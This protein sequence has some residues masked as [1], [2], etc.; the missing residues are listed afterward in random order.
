MK[1]KS[2]SEIRKFPSNK[3]EIDMS[4]VKE[5][6]ISRSFSMKIQL[7][8]FEPIDVFAA[9]KAV[10]EPGTTADEAAEISTGLHNACVRQVERDMQNI[11]DTRVA[12]F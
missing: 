2:V 9:H 8:Q 1:K 3:L 7:K 11:R 5:L 12:P 4:K 10:L 6:E